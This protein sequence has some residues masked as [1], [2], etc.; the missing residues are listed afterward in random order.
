MKLRCFFVL[1][2]ITLL[3]ACRPEPP[4]QLLSDE[5]LRDS[6]T[7]Q[8]NRRKALAGGRAEALFGVFD[9]PLSTPQREAMM[10]LYAYS[11]LTD[12]ANLDG[13]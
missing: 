12:L 13:E 10:F 2:A 1:L 6:V 11:P 9:Q 7:T 4:G 8:F 3:A 5:A